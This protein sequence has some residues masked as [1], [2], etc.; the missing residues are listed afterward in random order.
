MTGIQS[1]RSGSHSLFLQ[2]PIDKPRLISAVSIRHAVPS[3]ALLVSFSALRTGVPRELLVAV[4]CVLAVTAGVATAQPAAVADASPE[5]QSIRA[6]GGKLS[7]NAP[8]SW[9]PK[10]PS[11]RMI[12]HE[13]TIPAAD[14]DA[15][16]GRLTMM[17]AGGS[18][19][20]NLDRW[21]GQFKAG[22]SAKQTEWN[23]GEHKVTLLD[24]EGTYNDRRGPFAP[25]TVRDDYRML[26]GV[27]ELKTGGLFF[28][29]FYGPKAT[30]EKN[31]AAF[32]KMLGSK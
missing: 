19:K 20:A 17:S 12:E 22:G 28:V 30:I 5:T 26:G 8:A 14:G 11:I 3:P 16:G 25:P 23:W 9:K 24:L 4:V 7:L 32:R 13:L 29:K 18:V 6:A 21:K 31:A 2:P 27:V 1:A 10:K 15:Q